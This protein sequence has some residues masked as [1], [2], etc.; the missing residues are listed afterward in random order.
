MDNL[1]PLTE[2]DFKSTARDALDELP[3]EF[4]QKMQDVAV[5]LNSDDENRDLMGIYDPRGG[6]RRIVLFKDT[7]ERVGKTEK[8]IRR[9]IRKTVL[10]EVGHHFGLSESKLREL[11]YG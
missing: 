5:V 8:G 1:E 7:I 10:H 2:E 3:T 9:E 11:G 4:A 6:M